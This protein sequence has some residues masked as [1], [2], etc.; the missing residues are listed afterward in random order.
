MVKGVF[1]VPGAV[2]ATAERLLQKPG[3]RAFWAVR[4]RVL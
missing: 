3:K 1:S 2:S 4:I